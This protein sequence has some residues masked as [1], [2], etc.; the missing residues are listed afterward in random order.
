MGFGGGARWGVANT[1]TS[2]ALQ[3]FAAQIT[4]NDRPAGH[5]RRIKAKRVEIRR[6]A[7]NCGK[8]TTETLMTTDCTE[9]KFSNYFSDFSGNQCL[10]GKIRHEQS[11]NPLNLTRMPVGVDGAL[12]SEGEFGINH[13]DQLPNSGKPAPGRNNI[14]GLVSNE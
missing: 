13:A 9:K 7:V 3:A 14:G 8:E 5:A 12:G 4:K 10:T 1:L 11:P 6:V 2:E